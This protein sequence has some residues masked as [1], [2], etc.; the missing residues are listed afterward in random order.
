MTRALQTLLR[1]DDVELVVAGRT[2][3]GVHARAQVA[4]YEGP[5]PQLRSLNALL[6]DD[7]GVLAAEEMPDGWSARF[8]AKG[9]SYEYRVHTRRVGP[10]PFSM[11]RELW[12]PHRV[13]LEAL[14]SC[15]AAVVGEHDFTAFTPSD[16]Y[17]VRFTRVVSACSWEREGEE[18]LV[19]RISAD[20]FMR[21]MCRV[22]VGTM[23]EVA[24]GRRG[25]EDFVSL[26]GGAPRA[27][28]GVTAPAHGLYLVGG[29]Y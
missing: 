8:D 5:P 21:N 24:A 2:D 15:A 22:L 3:R 1:R 9:R 7:V 27:R 11:G 25:V 16:T 4:S 12:W 10:S 13:D 6:P 29:E 14:R 18:T 28:A 20:A 17:H 19:F 26:L 23:L